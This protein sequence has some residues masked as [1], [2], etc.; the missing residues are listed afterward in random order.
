MRL[1]TNISGYKI[2][3]FSL[4]GTPINH[5]RVRQLPSSNIPGDKGS[6]LRVTKDATKVYFPI[7]FGNYN[8]TY[9][10]ISASES[11]DAIQHD[12]KP[13][14]IVDDERLAA[15]IMKHHGCLSIAIQGPAGWHAAIGLADGFKELCEKCLEE[16]ITIVIRIS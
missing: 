15:N 4:D 14:I 13:L 7:N 11:E 10:T 16:D 5:F 8:G 1:P 6:L 2:P 3:Y 12:K 9:F